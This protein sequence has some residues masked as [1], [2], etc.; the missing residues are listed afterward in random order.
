MAFWGKNG[1]KEEIPS[2]NRATNTHSEGPFPEVPGEKGLSSSAEVAGGVNG[3]MGVGC[4]SIMPMVQPP[5][6]P[7]PRFRS[8]IPEINFLTKKNKLS[9]NSTRAKKKPRK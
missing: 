5:V 9:R 7:H 2:T 4:Q 1:G 3:L 8:Q 6:R